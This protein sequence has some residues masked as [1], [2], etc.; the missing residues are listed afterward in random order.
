MEIFRIATD[1]PKPKVGETWVDVS[2]GE[3]YI[4]AE[5]ERTVLDDIVAAVDDRDPRRYGWRRYAE[6]LGH[7]LYA[8]I[9][10]EVNFM[11]SGRK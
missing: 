5:L 9:L 11:Q 2:T 1:R 3:T 8:A 4:Y 6:L 7:N 10:D